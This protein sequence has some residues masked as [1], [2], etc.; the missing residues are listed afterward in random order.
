MAVDPQDEDVDICE[1][2]CDLPV[3]AQYPLGEERVEV[4]QSETPRGLEESAAPAHQVTLT[5]DKPISRRFVTYRDPPMSPDSVWTSDNEPLI[6]SDEDEPVPLPPKKRQLQMTESLP[7]KRVNL[8]SDCD[9][10][11]L[12]S[13]KKKMVKV[14]ENEDNITLVRTLVRTLPPNPHPFVDGRH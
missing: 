11:Y 13:F 6:S 7:P 1:A 12:G 4:T 2:V 5:S 9:V 3:L 14:A 8:D 10:V